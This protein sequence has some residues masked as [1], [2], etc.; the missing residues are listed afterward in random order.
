MT[1]FD[2]HTE[3]AAEAGD[4]ELM[5][6]RVL[7][8]VNAAPKMP[9]SSTVRLEKD[10]VVELLE[11]AVERLPDELRQARWL[12]KEREEY[13]AKVQREADDILAAARDRAERI[14][15]RTELVR[16]SQR[17]SRRILDEANEEARRLRHEAEDYCDQKLAS[18][19]IQLQRIMKTVH[20]GREKLQIAPLATPGA[21]AGAGIVDAEMDSGEVFFDQDQG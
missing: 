14:V 18:F 20:G 11:E 16:E 10:E 7:D 4:T 6:R 19:E 1:T 5:L 12:L 9:L 17:L 2:R 21:P 3:R 15:Q 8:L 13:L